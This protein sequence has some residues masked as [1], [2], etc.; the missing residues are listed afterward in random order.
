[1]MA[2]PIPMPL[3][4]QYTMP[5]PLQFAPTPTMPWN[6]NQNGWG[7]G[8]GQRIGKG[9]GNEKGKGKGVP[10]TSK[11]KGKGQ[12]EERRITPTQGKVRE[13][14]IRLERFGKR[15]RE[16]EEEEGKTVKFL[17]TFKGSGS[18]SERFDGAHV[19][20]EDNEEEAEHD[21]EDS[22]GRPLNLA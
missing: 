19:D 8:K 17:V 10:N 4:M 3:P 13:G 20:E 5:T 15:T 1:M 7:E 12:Q 21:P 11:G 18:L 6:Q 16:G 9:K 2:M 14:V 22:H